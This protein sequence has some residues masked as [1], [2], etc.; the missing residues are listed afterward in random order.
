MPVLR[1]YFSHMLA[2]LAQGVLHLKTMFWRV[3]SALPV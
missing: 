2:L 1:R 3:K